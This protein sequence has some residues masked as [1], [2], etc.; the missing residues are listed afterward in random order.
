MVESEHQTRALEAF[1]MDEGID[2]KCPMRAQEAEPR[3]LRDGK[4]GAHISWNRRRNTQRSSVGVR[5]T[6]SMD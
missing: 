1:T 4:S 6:G 2:A 3:P 5:G